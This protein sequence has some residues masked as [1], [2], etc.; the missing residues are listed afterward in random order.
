VLHAPSSCFLQRRDGGL[1]AAIIGR[2][3]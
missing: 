1:A 3:F 2:H